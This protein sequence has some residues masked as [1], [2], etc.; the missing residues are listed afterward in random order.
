MR[1]VRAAGI[2]LAAGRLETGRA[3]RGALDKPVAGR[4]VARFPPAW[5]RRLPPM[6]PPPPRLPPPAR[7]ISSPE[8]MIVV[9]IPTNIVR[10]IRIAFSSPCIQSSCCNF[11]N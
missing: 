8:Q 3:A 1:V 6:R 2:V 5:P 10:F 4:A 9:T 11:T 7:A